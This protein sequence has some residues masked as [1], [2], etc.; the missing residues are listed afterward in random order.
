MIYET[1]KLALQ[2]H[3]NNNNN[4]NNEGQSPGSLPI[5]MSL[6][7]GAMAGAAAQTAAHPL[8]VVRKRLQIQG[9]VAAKNNPILYRNLSHCFTSIAQTEGTRALYKGLRPACVA[10]IPGTGIAYIVYEFMKQR[11]LGL[12]TEET[13]Q[14]KAS[15]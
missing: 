1:G 10:T 5:W 13:N 15:T 8:D 11:V 14:K 12:H 6:G 9:F 7:L 3:Y 4:N 2:R